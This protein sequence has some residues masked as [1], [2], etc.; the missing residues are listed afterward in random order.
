MVRTATALLLHLFTAEVGS[1]TVDVKGR[2]TV[3]LKTFECRDIN[4]SSLIQRV[5]YDKTQSHLI[6]SI[7]G[8]Y[9]QYC[10]LPAQTFEG[11]MAA[12]S[13]GSFSIGI[14]GDLARMVRINA[15]RIVR[16]IG[17]RDVALE[18]DPEK[19]VPVFRKDHAQTK[20]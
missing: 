8:V 18:H 5:C 11:L 13:M 12:P 16:I 19:W 10:E 4:R 7:K 14:S 15:G 2:G 20:R 3:D 6:I 17:R 1:E 9:D